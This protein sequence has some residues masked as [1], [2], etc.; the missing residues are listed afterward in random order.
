MNGR[1]QSEII[2]SFLRLNK[3]SYAISE[4]CNS[5][6]RIIYFF[7]VPRAMNKKYACMH[8]DMCNYN[9]TKAIPFYLV[10]L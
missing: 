2:R 1:D 4:Y 7:Q 9:V 5:F 6:M 3:S 10:C 8:V